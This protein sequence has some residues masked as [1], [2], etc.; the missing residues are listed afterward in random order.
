MS[1]FCTTEILPS[2]R[3]APKLNDLYGH[4]QAQRPLRSPSSATAS[5]VTLKRNGLYGHPQ[6]QRLS[7]TSQTSEWFDCGVVYGSPSF[8]PVA[9]PSSRARPRLPSPPDTTS[10]A[11]VFTGGTPFIESATAVAIASDTTS[12]ALV[13]TGDTPFIES[14]T[15]VAIASDTTSRALVLTGDT[16]FIEYATAVANAFEAT[17]TGFVSQ[18]MSTESE[19]L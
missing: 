1:H 6:A 19:W 3:L 5:T 12:R 16:P 10:R 4:P 15:A 7:P 17:I 18:A 11:L 8:S 13:L 9:R 14:A 2:P